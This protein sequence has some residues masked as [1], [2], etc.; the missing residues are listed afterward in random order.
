MVDFDGLPLVMAWELTLACNLRCTHCGSAAG[1]PRAGELTTEEALSL[2]D[3]LPELLVQEVDF[4]GGEP[5]VRPDWPII[6]ARLT[7]LEIRTQIITNALALDADTVAEM[8]DVGILSVGLSLDGLEATHDRIRG[9]PGLYRRV[10]A[11]AEQVQ[12]AG[13]RCA[14]LTTVNALNV[15]E[16][17]AMYALLQSLDIAQWQVQPVFPLGRAAGAAELE[18]SSQRYMQMGETM[19]QLCTAGQ[20]GG[21]KVELADSFG[22]LSEL[23][24]REDP[25][26]GCSAGLVMCG[27]TSDGKI[28]GCLSLPDDLVEGDLRERDLWDIWLD[29]H[30]F[31]YNRHYC[32]EDLGPY[33]ADCEGAELCKGGCS[34]MSIGSTNAFHNDPYCFSGIRRRGEEKEERLPVGALSAET[35]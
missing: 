13:L 22:Y 6:A 20:A 25:W 17:P 28:K 3:Q 34:A 23:D 16:L 30:A 4:T 9:Y 11:G 2:C 10:L 19:R 1:L 26:R 33:C 32:A 29:P 18:L 7:Q 24:T 12:K 31:A 14:V 8:C 35:L 27:I 15:D 5:L 21:L